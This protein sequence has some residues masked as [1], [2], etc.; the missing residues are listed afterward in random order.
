ML[1]PHE[2]TVSRDEPFVDPNKDYRTVRTD[3][4]SSITLS[5]N[6]IKATPEAIESFNNKKNIQQ[7]EET[8]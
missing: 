7:I 5:N 1:M 8:D 3:R 2:S 6:A 4:K